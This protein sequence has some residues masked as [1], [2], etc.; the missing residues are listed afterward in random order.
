MIKL[1][2]TDVYGWE[3]AIRGMRNPLNSWDRS[4]SCICA[5]ANKFM[6][7]ENDLALA[8]KLIRAG[9]DHR[10]FLRQIFVSVDIT[11][12]RFWWTEFDT[13]RAGVEKNS[14][15]TMHTI[16][17]KPF[18]ITDFSVEEVCKVKQERVPII[19]DCVEWKEVFLEGVLVS[20]DGRVKVLAHDVTRS[21][22]VVLH[23][24]E[25]E[26]AIVEDDYLRCKIRRNGS[27]YNCR[28]H[29]LMAEAFI[30]N[31]NNYPVINHKDG[32]K[33][34][35]NLDNLEWCTSSYNRQ[36]ACDNGLV[37]WSVESRNKCGIRSRKHTD[38]EVE[39]IKAMREEGK[40]L[41]EIAKA[42]NS[43]EAIISRIVNGKSYVASRNSLELLIETLN[44][45][46]ELFL[47]T[48]DKVYWRQIIELLPQSYNQLRTCT[49]SYETLL[50]QY[51][52]RKNHKLDEWHVFC[53]WIRELPHS[54]IITGEQNDA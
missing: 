38:E 35:C 6:L 42:F 29:R 4:D 32:N 41:S 45:L 13:Y 33:L 48:N 46:R 2:K 19:V 25:R 53:D 17:K 1:E 20:N 9:S 51:H 47:Q 44:E 43:S 7:G 12:P 8:K 10:K 39:Q 31:P 37:N 15:S 49:I 27:T 22:G 36:H 23:I 3:A 5:D 40:T 18:E 54:E 16:H 14:C 21:D 52:A 34:N 50:H 28:L 30:P 24:P 11:A 26:I